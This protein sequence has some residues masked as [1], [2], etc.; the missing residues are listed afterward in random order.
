[1]T[2]AQNK[3]IAD[4]GFDVTLDPFKHSIGF[5][6]AACQNDTVYYTLAKH[7]GQGDYVWLYASNDINS[8]DQKLAQKFET[9]QALTLHGFSFYSGAQTP[10]DVK[11]AVYNVGP[12]GLPDAELAS[13]NVSVSAAGFYYANFTSP[14]S[15]TSDYYLVVDNETNDNWVAVLAN[16]HET[17]SGREENLAA[18]YYDGA[19]LFYADGDASW[20]RDGDIIFN[21]IIQYTTTVD[22]TMNPAVASPGQTVELTNTSSAIFG[23]RF[24][25]WNVYRNHFNDIPDS[26]F[27]WNLPNGLTYSENSTFSSDVAGS[28]DIKLYGI[29][30]GWTTVC[31]DSISKQISVSSVSVASINDEFKTIVFPNPSNGIINVNTSSTNSTI[32]IFNTLGAVVARVD[33]NGNNTVKVDLAG[34]PKGVYFVKINE[35]GNTS[36]SKVSIN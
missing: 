21:P 24:Y 22:F 12:D 14:V 26:T 11:A 13:I 17:S 6:R 33:S 3:R 19:W 16:N 23:S 28:F 32:E 36:V 5:S 18:T 30:I 35:N 10:T 20:G 34:Q 29:Q 8:D 25:N 15:I 1:M 7:I 31:M 27:A 2:F 4:P 9:P